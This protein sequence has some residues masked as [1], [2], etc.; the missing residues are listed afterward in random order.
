LAQR[1]AS[2]LPASR[3]EADDQVNGSVC[4]RRQRQ[5]F[6]EERRREREGYACDEL[7][8]GHERRHPSEE[9]VAV[10]SRQPQRQLRAV[11]PPADG[12]LAAWLRLPDG[13]QR[14]RADQVGDGVEHKRHERTNHSGGSG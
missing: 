4:R 11:K 12:G 10:Q 2:A 7:L 13:Q 8:S 6:Q 14:D 5:H 9:V 1:P 3:R